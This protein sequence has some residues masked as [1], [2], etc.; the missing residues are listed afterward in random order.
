MWGGGQHQHSD[1]R[2]VQR[3]SGVHFSESKVFV[4][5][6]LLMICEGLQLLGIVKTG[7][8]HTK[9]PVSNLFSNLPSH[10]MLPRGE[11]G[12]HQRLLIGSPHRVRRL[13]VLRDALTYR[14]RM[15]LSTP[16]PVACNVLTGISPG[17]FFSLAQI[18]PQR[19][20]RRQ[21]TCVLVQKVCVL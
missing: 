18:V 12:K 6:L 1:H 20:P 16:R 2:N 17:L 9:F 14:G 7:D 15:S 5:H 21:K 3:P 8:F 4:F 11:L 13:I 10:V 19:A